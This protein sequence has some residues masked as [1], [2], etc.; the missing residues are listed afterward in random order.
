MTLYQS[1]KFLS[2]DWMIVA[3]YKSCLVNSIQIITACFLL[4]NSSAILNRE[5]FPWQIRS[6]AQKYFLKIQKSGKSEHVPPP[7][8]KKKASHP[9]PQKAPKNGQ[10]TFSLAS[11]SIIWKPLG[12]MCNF[13]WFQQPLRVLGCIHLY[14]LHLNQDILTFQTQQQALD[15]PAHMLL[16]AVVQCRPLIFPK[17]PKVLAINLPSYCQRFFCF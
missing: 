15:F 8:P 1:L 6:H 11:W 10:Y 13:W 7:R 16:G 4:M 12:L 14:L 17:Y 2:E 9:Y 5:F 3:F